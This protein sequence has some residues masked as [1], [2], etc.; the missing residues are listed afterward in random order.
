MIYYDCA[1]Y[2]KLKVPMIVCL[3]K[4]KIEP[5]NTV[6]RSLDS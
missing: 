6:S 3:I 5:S 4:S 1:G 2:I